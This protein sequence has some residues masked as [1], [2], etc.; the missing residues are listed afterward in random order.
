MDTVSNMRSVEDNELNYF[1]EEKKKMKLNEEYKNPYK[2]NLQQQSHT[3]VLANGEITTAVKW[4]DREWSQLEWIYMYIK[5][6]EA[7]TSCSHISAIYTCTCK[8]SDKKMHRT[9]FNRQEKNMSM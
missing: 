9:T 4:M 1:L 3:H 5:Y 7:M 2:N 8:L 6:I